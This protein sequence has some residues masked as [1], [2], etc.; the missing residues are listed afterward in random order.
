MTP[1]KIVGMLPNGRILLPMVSPSTGSIRKYVQ[2]CH[3]SFT[4][5]ESWACRAKMMSK[6]RCVTIFSDIEVTP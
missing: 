5:R 4:G 1:A 2:M 6:A 3:Y